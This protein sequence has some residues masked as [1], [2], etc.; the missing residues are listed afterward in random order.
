MSCIHRLHFGW[1][2]FLLLLTSFISSTFAALMISENRL[3]PSITADTTGNLPTLKA[4]IANVSLSCI[5]PASEPDW[6]GPIDATDCPA[7]YF[8][9]ANEVS[10]YEGQDFTF[11]SKKF[12]PSVQPSMGW[13]LPY[14]KTAGKAITPTPLRFHSIVQPPQLLQVAASSSSASPRILEMMCCRYLCLGHMNISKRAIGPYGSRTMGLPA[15]CVGGVTPMRSRKRA[16]GLDDE[17]RSGLHLDVVSD[18][19]CNGAVV[20]V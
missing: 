5:L 18:G 12:R 15:A 6:A 4:A 19:K 2:R 20:V 10:L 3:H 1:C 13:E 14:G 9:L 11:W 16:A 7:A 8:T 17:S